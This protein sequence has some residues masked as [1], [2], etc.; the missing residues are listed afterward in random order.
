MTEHT[1]TPWTIEKLHTRRVIRGASGKLVGV[2]ESGMSDIDAEYLA[3]LLTVPA[4]M[5]AASALLGI[6]N[7]ATRDAHESHEATIKEL[8]EAGKAAKALLLS[9]AMPPTKLGDDCTY[10]FDGALVGNVLTLLRAALK[11]A[12]ER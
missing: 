6:A 5:E 3:S 11:N 1:P 2:L 7:R 9:D 10:H 4:K 12:G 8:V